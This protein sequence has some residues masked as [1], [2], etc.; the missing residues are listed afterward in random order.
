MPSGPVVANDRALEAVLT[1]A[2]DESQ[3]S[4]F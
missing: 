4:R 2:P 1:E 3:F